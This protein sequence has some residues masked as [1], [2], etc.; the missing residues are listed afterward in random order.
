VLPPVEPETE[1]YAAWMSQLE[2]G[3]IQPSDDPR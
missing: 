3:M 2:E 1:G